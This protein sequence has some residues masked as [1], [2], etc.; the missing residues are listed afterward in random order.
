MSN[1]SQVGSPPVVCVGEVVPDEPPFV[2]PV[3]K[4]GGV[5][6]FGVIRRLRPILGIKKIGHA[7]TLDPAATGLL[8]CLVGR[9]ATKLQDRFMGQRKTYTG[10]IRLGA[11]T[12]T[13]DA[14]GD[15]VEIRDTSSVTDEQIEAARLRFV[16]EIEQRPPMYSAIKVDGQRLYKKARRGE[17][18]ER[19]PRQVSVYRFDLTARRG[20]ALDFVVEC[21]KGTY[22]RSLAFDLG[23]SLGV[24]AHLAALRRTRI[25]DLDVAEAW[26]LDALRAHLDS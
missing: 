7:G 10:T 26:K 17:E 16:G 8:V 6:S 24:G 3:D 14:E 11:T 21:S 5:S 1:N 15:V 25:G 19:P 12:T 9:G 20:D 13:Y 4:P 18:V 2:L 22:I 23:E